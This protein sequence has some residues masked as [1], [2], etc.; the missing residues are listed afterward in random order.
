MNKEE[1]T[2]MRDGI[3]SDLRA[4]ITK[5]MLSMKSNDKVSEAEFC[6]IFTE[7]CGRFTVNVMASIIGTFAK[8]D[9]I[10]EAVSAFAEEVKDNIITALKKMGKLPVEH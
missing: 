8:P 7:A 6:G 9:Q 2:S 5:H 10:K 4:V 1:I 3:I